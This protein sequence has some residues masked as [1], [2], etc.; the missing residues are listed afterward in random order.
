[1]VNAT[2]NRR[3]Q[4]AGTLRRTAGPVIVVDNASDDGTPEYVEEAFPG[5]TVI[6]LSHNAGAAARNLGVQAART[7][8][9]AFA[10]DDSYWL[11][12]SLETAARTL[13]EHPQVGLVTARVLV[14]P[15]ARLDPVSAAMASAPLGVPDGCPGPA[16]LGFLSC[17][18]VVRRRAYLDVGGFNP[19]LHVYG[20]EALLALD[21]AAAGW[22]L[23]YVPALG[24]RHLPAQGGRDVRARSRMEIRNRLLTALLRRPAGVVGRSVADALR[25]PAGRGALLDAARMAPWALRHRRALPPEVEAARALLDR[26]AERDTGTS[27][28]PAPSVAGPADHVPLPTGGPAG[29]ADDQLT[30]GRRRR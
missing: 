17:A 10:D 25:T 5:T 19:A 27:R 4:L 11:P 7:P 13:R 6:R 22:R 1:V 21:L 18:A 2:R 23:A 28:R 3:R 26:L 16:V 8:F 14:G 15:Q 30:A 20:E 24:V 29:S 9:V 12:G